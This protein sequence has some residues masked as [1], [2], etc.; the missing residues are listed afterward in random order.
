MP[1][2]AE[3]RSLAISGLVF[4]LLFFIFGTL[5]LLAEFQVVVSDQIRAERMEALMGGGAG[6]C[7][8]VSL[9]SAMAFQSKLMIF[10]NMKLEAS[11]AVTNV[12][13]YFLFLAMTM[14][15]ST[16]RRSSAITCTISWATP[17]SWASSSAPASRAG[18][19]TPRST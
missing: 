4:G 5:T 6:L 1:G 14:A 17:S 2:K 18:R 8:I 11:Q 13:F 10:M 7:F 15:G 16:P 3:A 9:M 12:G 19:S